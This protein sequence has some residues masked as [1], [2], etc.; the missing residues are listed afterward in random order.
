MAMAQEFPES[1]PQNELGVINK[2]WSKRICK[3]K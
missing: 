2:V 1:A 3:E